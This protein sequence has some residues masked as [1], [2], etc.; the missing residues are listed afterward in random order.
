MN[1]LRSPRPT[2]LESYVQSGPVVPCFRPSGPVYAVELPQSLRDWCG[3]E[4]LGAASAVVTAAWLKEV[5]V[6]AVLL[7]CFRAS[8][9]L[10]LDASEPRLQ[11]AVDQ[12]RAQ[13][14]VN[15]GVQVRGVRRVLRLP[16][17]VDGV[18]GRGLLEV[19]LMQGAEA[20]ARALK[21]FTA[22]ER[23]LDG[24][25]DARRVPWAAGRVVALPPLS[26]LG[27]EAKS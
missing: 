20:F 13:G 7:S 23:A 8:V 18:V 15:L 25:A 19:G 2:P 1:S 16:V 3:V 11:A 12:W 4:A 6:V 14:A 5:A 9:A 21:D 26:D 17:H 22:V 24:L 27:K 10:V